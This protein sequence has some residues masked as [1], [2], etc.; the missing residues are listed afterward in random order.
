MHTPEA[1]GRAWFKELK[2]KLD[3]DN[4][5]VTGVNCLGGCDCLT[6]GGAAAGCCSVGL[7]GEGRFSYV[8]NQ[9]E[10]EKDELKLLEL[11]RRYG[12]RE[13]G[14]LSCGDVP[15]LVPHIA[16]RLPPLK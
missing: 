9:F 16:T 15:E 10:P 3:N 7:M 6:G 5:V 11:L 12:L 13:D 8:M 4:V 1:M 14:K 2:A